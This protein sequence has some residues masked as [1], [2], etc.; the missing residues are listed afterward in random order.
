VAEFADRHASEREAMGF[1]E[2]FKRF[3]GLDYFA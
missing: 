2:A 1:S 3:D